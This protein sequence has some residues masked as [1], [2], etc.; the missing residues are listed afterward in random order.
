MEEGT[1]DSKGESGMKQKAKEGKKERKKANGVECH[2]H[3]ICNSCETPGRC[4][5]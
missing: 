4:P 1:E 5:R 2:R 3:S